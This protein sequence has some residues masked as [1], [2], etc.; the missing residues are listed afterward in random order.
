LV[1]VWTKVTGKKVTYKQ[2][3]IDVAHAD[4]PKEMREK[5]KSSLGLIDEYSYYGPTGKQDLEWTLA[6]LMEAPTSWE[7]FVRANEPWFPGS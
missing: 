2:V 7:D 5:L 1:D 3:E 6:Q 4:M